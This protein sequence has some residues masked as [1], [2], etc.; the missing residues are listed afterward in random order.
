MSPK[1][2][3]R[4]LAGFGI[5][6]LGAILVVTIR[7][8]RRR[9]PEQIPSQI[10]PLI[11]GALL[12]ARNFHWT[13]M[14]G[15]QKEWVLTAHDASYADDRTSVL[16]RDAKVTMTASDGKAVMLEAPQVTL[17]MNGNH[18]QQANMTG[19][20]TV[21]YGDFVVTTD[22]AIFVPD[23]DLITAPGAVVVS[24]QGIKVT[25]VGLIGH[26]HQQQF[27]LGSQVNTEIIQDSKNSQGSKSAKPRQ[28]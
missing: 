18:V 6:A 27:D 20:L 11:P 22:H 28:S 9:S 1:R 2:I 13:Q 23:T 19:G 26:P 3:A 12:H 14:K 5:V 16:L 7:V 15:G 10:V 21:H 25:G 24:G 4:V 8:V 17:K